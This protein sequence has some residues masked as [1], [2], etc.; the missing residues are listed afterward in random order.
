MPTT[1]DAVAALFIGQKKLF[2]I[3]VREKKLFSSEA[4]LDGALTE[5]EDRGLLG[6]DR[7]ANRY[8]LHPIVRGVVWTGL[9]ES[10]RR[11]TYGALEAHFQSLPAVHED[12]VNRLEDV[13]GAIELY[14]TLIGLGR[15]DDACDLFSNRLDRVTLFRLSA[16]RDRGELLEMLFPDG[17][18][19]LPRLRGRKAQ[20][21]TL[22]ALA[23]GYLFTGQSAR[24]VPHFR[25]AIAIWD[26][27][28]DRTNLETGLENLSEAL[29]TSG[30]LQEAE[31]AARRALSIS[32]RMNSRL[33]EAA[34]LNGL[35][36][37][38]A[39][40]GAANDGEAVLRRSLRIFKAH[41][42]TQAEGLVIANLAQQVLWLGKPAR[43]RSM[44][45]RAWDL[46]HARGYARDFVCAARL[47]GQ[48]ALGLNDPC[49]ADERLHHALTRARAV[50]HIEEELAA[51]TGLAEL[52]R[53][54]GD[55]KAARDLL[56]YVWEPAERGPSPLLHADALNV[57]AQIERD[58]S[59]TDPSRRQAA[60]EAATKAYRLAW[61]DGPPFAYHWG[62]EA[63][64]KHLRELGAP[65]PDMPPFDE[66]KYEPMPEVEI[67]PPDEYSGEGK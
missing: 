21:Y 36:S 57:L 32:R 15:Y 29:R 14:N 37:A 12:E 42:H 6:W 22:R 27:E 41:H 10:T 66:S 28:G 62:L 25:M 34:S 16:S 46:A 39:A 51:L 7:R 31:A 33:D 58:A 24:A 20:A 65:E 55:L 8:D 43:A 50:N 67:N 38:L 63:A 53:R 23:Q 35:G 9:D 13:T 5:L 40:R 30:A 47:Q 59:Q 4:K 49:T 61:C 3:E 52:Q 54:Q 44:T 45:D 26:R 17:P 19:Q 11:T 1:Y 48:A 56:D 18:E 2:S 64:R 60:I